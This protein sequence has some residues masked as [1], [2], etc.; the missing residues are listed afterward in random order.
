APVAK[1]KNG[2][3]IGLIVLAVVIVGLAVFGTQ[4]YL[5]GRNHVVTDNAQVEGHIVP[6]I[7]RVTGYVTAVDATENQNV[8]A[9]DLLVQIDERDLR[10]KLAQAEA[11]LAAAR[12]AG[13]PGVVGTAE[14]QLAAARATVEQAKANADRAEADVERYR[15]LAPRGVVSRQQLDAAEAAARS[16]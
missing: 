12:A 9:G 8:K 6:V 10:A 16:S 13:G 7:A 2:P 14:A 3:T 15:A 1:K 11:D 5:Y 4:R